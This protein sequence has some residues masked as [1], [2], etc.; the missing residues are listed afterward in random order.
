MELFT[1]VI[2]QHM[3]QTVSVVQRNQTLNGAY[4]ISEVVK[5]WEALL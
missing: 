2:A 5:L 3:R 4:H 1:Q